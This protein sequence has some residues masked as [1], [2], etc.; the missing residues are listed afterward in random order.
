M[1][2][3]RNVTVDFDCNLAVPALSFN[4]SGQSDELFGLQIHRG[5]TLINADSKYLNRITE[6]TCS[7]EVFN[8]CKSAKI[9]GEPKFYSRI[10]NSYR[11][12]ALSPAARN[13]FRIARAILPDLPITRPMSSS[14]T[15]SS[16]T[17]SSPSSTSSTNTASG[18]FTS[19]LA[20]NS[21]AFNRRDRRVRRELL[22]RPRIYTDKP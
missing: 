12:P 17:N 15:S 18:T 20:T 4:H 22:N 11:R 6:I 16:T 10:S 19:A 5:F 14:A 1:Q 21:K 9:R 2:P 13:T 8:P 3:I 7:F